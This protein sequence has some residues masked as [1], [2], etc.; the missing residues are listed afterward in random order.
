VAAGPVGRNAE[1]SGTASIKNV[2]AV[3]SYSKT[4]GLFAGVSLEGSVIVERFD[5]NAKMYG[6]KVKARDLLNGTIPPPPSADPLYRALEMRFQQNRPGGRFGHGDHYTSSGDRFDRFDSYDRGGYNNNNTSDYHSGDYRSD[7]RYNDD[8]HQ[9]D[10]Y[11][12]NSQ[13]MSFSRGNVH[14][15]A[16]TGSGGG[17]D[18]YGNGGRPRGNSL[19]NWRNDSPLDYEPPR[20]ITSA[21]PNTRSE[22]SRAVVVSNNS[23]NTSLSR[24]MQ[25]ARALFNFK[26]E[27]DGDLPFNKGD[28]ICIVKKTNTTNDWWT[29][30]LNGKQGIVSYAKIFYYYYSLLIGSFVLTL[31]LSSF[32][33][34]FYN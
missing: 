14:S 29:G 7:D 23:T 24:D 18:Y 11:N 21:A 3:Y 31:S 28:V 9:S 26:G 1:A 13:P 19:G 30:V 12:N 8:R 4:R 27:Q 15:M 34:I 10:S 32:L 17:T 6:G 2:S 22:S 20:H 25:K 5:A 16:K 33:L